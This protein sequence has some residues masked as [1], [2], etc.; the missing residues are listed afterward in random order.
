MIYRMIAIAGLLI[1]IFSAQAT[2]ADDEMEGPSHHGMGMKMGMGYHNEEMRGKGYDLEDRFGGHFL[3]AMDCALDNADT[4]QLSDK[5]R[6]D[7]RNL[8]NNV[9]KDVL[10][11]NAE[12]EIVELDIHS[13]LME[14]KVDAKSVKALFKKAL[15]LKLDKNEALVDNVI[16]F[17]GMLSADQMAK[18]KKMMMK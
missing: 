11:K 10:R 12:I 3:H 15:A 5:Q 18:L 2:F 4:L 6:N 16:A 8:S 13:G 1:A 9:M 17:K 7:I 14:D